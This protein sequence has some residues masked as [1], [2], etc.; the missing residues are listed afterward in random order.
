MDHSHPHVSNECQMLDLSLPPHH[1]AY[2]LYKCIPIKHNNRMWKSSSKTKWYMHCGIW[3]AFT[4]MHTCTD[5]SICVHACT[6]TSK[7]CMLH[8]CVH[9]CHTCYGY[10]DCMYVSLHAGCWIYPLYLCIIGFM[11]IVYSKLRSYWYVCGLLIQNF[12]H[13]FK[14]YTHFSQ[15]IS[16]KATSK[17]ITGRRADC[18]SIIS[19]NE[20]NRNI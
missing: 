16:I 14:W 11:E 5:V 19:A 12:S 7:V 9:V 3:Y 4:C 17:L 8:G 18:P 1:L 2:F 10:T 20:Q 6:D 15:N 13:I